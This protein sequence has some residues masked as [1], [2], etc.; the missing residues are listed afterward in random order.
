MAKMI[1]VAPLPLPLLKS[2]SRPF[3]R[4]ASNT[5]K[6]FP[7]LGFQLRQTG[8]DVNENEYGAIMIF[9]VIFYTLFFSLLLTLLLSK[10]MPDKSLVVGIGLGLFMGAMVFVQVIMYPAL[11]VKKKVN[12]VEKNL[13]FA[14]RAILVQIKS[15]VSLF[16]S[17]AM[18]ARG[19]YEAISDEFQKAIDEINT[20]TPEQAAIERMSENNPSPFLRKSLWQI[21]N[22][23]NAGA[24]I[25][26]VL[27]ETVSS[28]IREQ[29]IAINK[30]GSQLRVL[31]LMY[32][33]IGVIMPALG[34]TLLIILFTFPMVG[35][36][37]AKQPALN[38]V[39]TILQNVLPGEAYMQGDYI[40][41]LAGMQDYTGGELKIRVESIEGEKALFV[42]M[43]EDDSIIG[44]RTVYNTNA[45][46]RD[47]FKTGDG[48]K[49]FGESLKIKS[50]GKNIFGQEQVEITRLEPTQLIF[51]GLIGLVAVME[52][53]YIGIIKSRRPSIIG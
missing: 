13:V 28:M 25:S 14:L 47:E 37:V 40:T 41:G 50:I 10:V 31:S 30:Y 36:A 26:D 1:P 6:M 39:T 51:W 49:L 12:A 29:K 3:L 24:D 21:V 52:F 38:D 11:Q 2:M 18:V 16:D 33:M 8:L 48:R 5:G 22:G 45:N 44:G 42:L 43:K 53:M 46:L 7:Q 4:M 19:N 27:G 20:G 17:M 9:L 35:E 32:M 23:M 34:V 15:G